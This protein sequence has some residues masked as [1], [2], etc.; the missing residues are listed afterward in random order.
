MPMLTLE[1]TF[2]RGPR[3]IGAARILDTTRPD[4]VTAWATAAACTLAR[5]L[6]I[7]HDKPE[8]PLLLRPF[9]DLHA[10]IAAAHGG[11]A[12]ALEATLTAARG[13]ATWDP[14]PTS[15][16]VRLTAEP[17]PVGTPLDK[18]PVI[19]LRKQGYG[20]FSLAAMPPSAAEMVAMPHL[21]FQAAEADLDDTTAK[22]AIAEALSI[23]AQLK[24][25]GFF[26]VQ[27]PGFN[28]AALMGIHAARKV[29]GLVAATP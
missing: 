3:P 2:P 17:G 14:A 9:L 7:C 25:K 15:R 12:T 19:Y 13:S 29:A 5:L 1:F 6:A 4:R 21:V 28:Q 22:L 24:A 18:L 20:L 10:P 27:A 8:E 11:D 16:R 23:V 26:A